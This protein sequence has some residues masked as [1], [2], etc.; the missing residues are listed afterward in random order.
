MSSTPFLFEVPKTHPGRVD[1]L[2]ALKKRQGIWTWHCKE[3]RREDHPWEALLVPRARRRLAGYSGTAE[4][5]APEDLIMNYCRL[6]EEAG[7]LVSG[8]TELQAVRALCI[9]NNMTPP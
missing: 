1:R 3:F 5:D 7:L 9:A 8:E 2:K 4:S 6:L